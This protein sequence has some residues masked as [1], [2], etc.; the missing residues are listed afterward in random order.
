M[1]GEPRTEAGQAL[2]KELTGTQEVDSFVLG[3]ESFAPAILAIE[4]QARRQVVEEIRERVAV[5]VAPTY[6]GQ[7]ARRV[8]AW[9]N[10]ILDSLSAAHEEEESNG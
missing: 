9:L 10:A 1:S 2:L 3:S 7:A 6:N 5:E 4:S 8:R